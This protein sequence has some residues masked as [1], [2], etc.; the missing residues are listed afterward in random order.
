MGGIK[1]SGEKD[2][3]SLGSFGTLLLMLSDTE[4]LTELEKTL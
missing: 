2:L 1:M 3:E 4:Q